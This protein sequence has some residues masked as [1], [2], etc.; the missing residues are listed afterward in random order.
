MGRRNRVRT[1]VAARAM[2]QAVDAMIRVGRE[3]ARLPV[4][5]AA[6]SRPAAAPPP[7]PP[8]RLS[9]PSVVVR[10]GAQGDGRATDDARTGRR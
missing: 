7:P 5:T 10:E 3:G 4:V 8:P 6:R 1:A 2:L 9:I